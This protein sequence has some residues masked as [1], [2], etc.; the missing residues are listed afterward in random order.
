MGKFKVELI[1]IDGLLPIE[2]HSKERALFIRKKI[3]AR[4]SWI[5]PIIVEKNH[6]LVLE[7]HHRFSACKAMGF[8]LVPAMMIDYSD[9]SIRSLRRSISF[10]KEEVV[11]NA[12]AGK[13]YPY[14]TVKHDWNFEVPEIEVALEELK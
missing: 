6:R 1:A 4:G 9:A 12:L 3:E 7:G 11:A 13:L 8:K 14:K 5:R 2:C 10:T